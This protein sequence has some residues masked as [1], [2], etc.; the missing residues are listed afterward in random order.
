MLYH[1]NKSSC[2]WLQCTV[3]H[4][5]QVPPS[6]VMELRQQQIRSNNDAST[7]ASLRNAGVRPAVIDSFFL[8]DSIVSTYDIKCPSTIN[9]ALVTMLSYEPE[10]YRPVPPMMDDG[11]GDIIWIDPDQSPGLMWDTSMC[12]ATARG[13]EVKVLM[14]KAFTGE[15]KHA[16]QECV[17]AELK[18]DPKLV[19]RCGLT[20]EKLPA[21]VENNPMIAIECLLSLMKYNHR[22]ITDYLTAL[23]NM[24]MSLHSMEVVNKITTAVEL[25]KEFIHLYVSNCITSCENIKDASKQNRLARLVCVFLQS[26]IRNK[27]VD[28]RDVFIEVQAFCIEFSRIKEAA[29]LFKMLKNME[30]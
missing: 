1:I 10:F 18:I 25:P 29:G 30:S 21:L 17:I 4:Q 27:I 15:L 22:E 9:P 12:A 20:P 5:Y 8:D 13:A 16:Q 2:V 6:K 19:Y 24:D 11:E 26:L 7:M 23:V 28:V 3:L 14:D